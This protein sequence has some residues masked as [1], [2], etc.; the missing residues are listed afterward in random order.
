VASEVA[1]H[2]TQNARRQLPARVRFILGAGGAALIVLAIVLA[3]VGGAGRH[4]AKRLPPPAKLPEL[5]E[6]YIN[7]AMGA[8]GLLPAGWIAIKGPGLLRL[9]DRSGD[10]VILI[11]ALN[12]GPRVRTLSQTLGELRQAYG[13]L[14]IKHDIG[15][16]LGGLPARSVVVY[17]VNRRHVPVRILVAVAQAPDRA[18][19]VEAVTMRS[20]PL[21]ALVQSQE[22]LNTMHFRG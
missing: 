5:R 20:A 1:E 21:Q 4:H 19:V 22:A 6:E 9:S 13:H 17:A 3:T 8:D 7:K 16:R 15:R 2:P 12:A 11:L 10:A 14:T 18:Y